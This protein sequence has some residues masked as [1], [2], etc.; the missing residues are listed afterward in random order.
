MTLSFT[1]PR[2]FYPGARHGLLEQLLC[3]FWEKT[4]WPVRDELSVR[5]DRDF[6]HLGPVLAGADVKHCNVLGADWFCAFRELAVRGFPD[7]PKDPKSQVLAVGFEKK[8]VLVFTEG[9]FQ[10]D[11][12]QCWNTVP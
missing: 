2:R 12:S 6:H 3:A 7:S 11:V 4:S 1:T 9:R 5:S 8:A 10:K